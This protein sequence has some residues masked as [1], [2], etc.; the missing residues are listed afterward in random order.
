MVGAIDGMHTSISK[1]RYGAEDYYYFKLGDYPLN[2]QAMVD[3]NKRFL[4]LY[5][6]MFY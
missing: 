5:L 4:D 1:P 6:A 3:S 2:F